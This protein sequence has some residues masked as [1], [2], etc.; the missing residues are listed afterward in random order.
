MDYSLLGQWESNHETDI[1]LSN[2][3]DD[4]DDDIYFDEEFM[5]EG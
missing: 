1:E 5:E 3:T 2:Q 4:I